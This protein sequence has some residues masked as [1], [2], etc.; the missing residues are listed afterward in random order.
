MTWDWETAFYMIATLY[1]VV[2]LTVLV[3]V[4][5]AGWI[6]YQR[7]KTKLALIESTIRAK[8]NVAQFTLNTAKASVPFVATNLIKQVLKHFLDRRSG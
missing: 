5:I 1:M 3:G 8:V 7:I 2:N 4:M 6:I